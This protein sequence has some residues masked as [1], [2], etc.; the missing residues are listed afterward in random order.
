VQRCLISRRN[1]EFFEFRDF[2][3]RQAKS[4]QRINTDSCV[5]AGVIEAEFKPKRILD[6]GAGTGVVSLMLASKF[7]DAVV[8]AV[9]PEPIITNIA[10]ENFAKSLWRDRLKIVECEAQRLTKDIHGTFDLLASNPPYFMSGE[11][12][13]EYLRAVA[14]HTISLGPKEVFA[15]FRELM[16]ADGQGWISCPTEAQKAWVSVALDFE[17]YHR[18]TIYLH[19]HPGAKSHVVVLSFSTQKNAVISE[20]SVHYK[21]RFQGDPSLWMKSFRKRWFPARFPR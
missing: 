12:S 10:R 5:F 21:D 13:A 17:L 18:E 8:T 6:I 15:A 4:G 16:S 1:P 9:E 7:E 11:P 2:T 3:M 19:D 20:R 14:R